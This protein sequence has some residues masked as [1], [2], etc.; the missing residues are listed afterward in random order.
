LSIK[1]FIINN[2]SNKMKKLTILFLIIFTFTQAYSQIWQPLGSGMNNRVNA[3]TDFDGEL[4]AGGFFQT[5]GGVNVNSIAAWN[6]YSNAWTSMGQ[7]LDSVPYGQVHSLVVAHLNAVTTALFA[8]GTFD[9]AG[10]DTAAKNIAQWDGNSWTPLGY[11]L[12]GGVNAIVSLNIPQLIAGGSFTSVRFGVPARYIAQWNG[13]S[14]DSLPGGVF[15]DVIITLIDYNGNL[16]AGGAFTHVGGA[17]VNY[18][19][20]WN[21]SYWTPLGSGMDNLVQTLM[22]YDGELIA[23]GLFTHAGGVS[24]NHVARWNGSSWAPLGS[25]LPDIPNALTEFHDNLIAG[26]LS[27]SSY[28]I[29]KWDGSSWSP[30]GGGAN[31]NVYALYGSD[32]ALYAEGQFTSVG[33]INANHIAKWIEPGN[34]IKHKNTLNKPI[35]SHESELDSIILYYLFGGGYDNNSSLYITDV[36]VTIDSVTYPRDSDLE[37]YLIHQS[38]TDTII[39]QN[40]GNGANF[41]G[42][43]LNDSASILISSGT[44]P[45]TGSY[46]PYKPLS[47]FN[48]LDPG[49]NWILKV[50]D[51][52]T[53]NTGTLEAWSL[54]ISYGVNPIGIKPVSSDVPKSFNLMQNYPNPFNPSTKIKFSVSKAAFTKLIIYDVLGR[55]ITTLVNEQLKP[56]SYEIE[57]NAANFSSGVY[58]YR[59]ETDGF[60]KTKEMVLIK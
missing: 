37:F 17:S 28:Y 3:L 2:W 20:Q 56:G 6:G 47:Q 48:G 60:S 18:I 9:K 58:F 24:A 44:A 7:G 33:G 55:E 36:N 22:I 34:V 29:Y 12:D 30:F 11:G 27:G 42:T 51:K 54:N 16:I 26:T 31:N 57:W 45:F 1:Y 14:W 15:S 49:G 40:G 53:G 19:A 32:F 46:K 50:Y 23:G 59:M 38:V 43:T 4:I 8:G 35:I 5:A 13:S 41:I 39:Y 52:G 25:G 10:G 21:G